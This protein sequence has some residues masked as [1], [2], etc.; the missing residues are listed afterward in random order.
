MARVVA[1]RGNLRVTATDTA[2]RFPKRMM[3]K[4][5]VEIGLRLCSAR[6]RNLWWLGDWLVAYGDIDR[7]SEITGETP[8]T[9]RSLRFQVEHIPALIRRVELRFY[10]HTAVMGLPESEQ[11]M[12]LD[13]AVEN[14]WNREDL[15]AAIRGEETGS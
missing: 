9:L 5:M 13:A 10:T 11:K 15:R 4:D 3:E 2:L 14:G 8:E 1:R 6:R 12:W 7:A